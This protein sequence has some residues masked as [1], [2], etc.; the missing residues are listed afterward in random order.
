MNKLIPS[1]FGATRNS[2]LFVIGCMLL[3]ASVV[4]ANEDPFV[5][6]LE[7]EIKTIGDIKPSFIVYKDKPLPKV[8]INYILKRYIKLF[9]SANSPSVKI[10][11]LNRINNLRAKYQLDSKKLTIDK[12][13]QSKVVLDSY[14]KIVNSGVFYQ[15]MD[16]LL[17]QTAK[18]TKFTG[19]DKETIKRLKL[20]V[21]L[22]PKSDL[23]DESMF[24]I[25]ET[26]FDLGEF[27]KAEAH[28]K[29]V[30]AFSKESTFHHESNFKL[31]W[32]IFRQD[33]LEEAAVHA[34]K[35]LDKYPSLRNA[36]SYDSLGLKE[37][38]IV[39]DTFRLLSTMFSQKKGVEDI[40]LLQ[41]S[42]GHKDYAYLLYDSLFRFALG[43]ER[44]SD[45]G[46]VARGFADN[47]PTDFNA[48]RMAQN[49][50]KTYRRGNFDI[51]EW[52]AKEN[53][54][55]NFGINSAYWQSINDEQKSTVRPL[56]AEVLGELAHLY[57]VRMQTALAKVKVDTKSVE[58]ISS[59]SSSYY[60]Y[61]KQ[62]ADY[63]EEL[64]ATQNKDRHSGE[65][66]YLAAEAS[67][68]IG[69]YRRAISL[70]ER[71]AYE[72]ISHPKAVNAGYA[73]VLTYEDLKVANGTEGLELSSDDKNRRRIA[74]EKF[75]ANFPMAKETPSL[76]NDLANE[77]YSEND[78]VK[79]V[80]VSSRVASIR[81]APAAV[82][83]SSLLVNAHS[84]FELKQ[85]AQAQSA[86]Q[87]LLSYNKKADVEVLSERL[88]A[89]VYRQAENEADIA[90]SAELYL[91]VVDLVPDASFAPQ[92]LFDAST[93]LLK[94][95]RWSQAI[96]T[97]NV[98]QGRFPQHE[99]YAN[100]S[101]KLVFA[102]IENQ[103][104]V[105][106]AEK[107]VEISNSS[108][109]QT[110]ASNS[111]YRA[112]EIYLENDFAFEATNLFSAFIQKFPE[113]FELNLEAYFQNISYFDGRKQHSEANKWR[114]ELVDYEAANRNKRSD[115][116][117]YLAAN[118]ALSLID[119]DIDR[120]EEIQLTLPLKK[121]LDQKKRKLKLI[122]SSLEDLA[123]YEVSEVISAAT[124]KIATIYRIL[125]Q[126]IMSSER[127]DKL[128]ELQL[129][130][131][132]IL[133]EEQAYT[134]EEQ[135][136]EIYQI[137]LD[138]VPEG[139]YDEW[140]AASYEMLAEMNP[141]EFERKSKVILHADEYY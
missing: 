129:E 1:A 102:Y 135:A 11:A 107:L 105:P 85:F 45:A 39:D 24:R 130:Q 2:V 90:K 22:Y 141:T 14:D 134:F 137:N 109:D 124:Y 79:A 27:A 89:S 104:P 23:V 55:K 26:Y 42:V 15:R 32:S 38:D 116:S 91:R 123:D 100:A 19:N 92:A 122:V 62:A 138:K 33:R 21:G 93:Q 30:L 101:E 118:A 71:S 136:L 10:D 133:L 48:Y 53:F 31:G 20:L 18:A 8:S 117:A 7:N 140:I 44:F 36:I 63:Y 86:Y 51:Q 68:R 43:Q 120:F 108:N 6:E 25:A 121:S 73:S 84:H 97:L 61:G 41:T 127:P 5:F 46:L 13:T 78:Y 119:K 35:V 9:E 52:D 112:A 34:S 106:A 125:A 70:Y 40:E 128:T 132:D 82:L 94:L 96:A 103:E 57:Y 64:V 139:E 54:A 111:L 4:Q 77:F 75:A 114:H 98:F 110:I 28:Y 72:H 69:D 66:L 59:S 80:E 37:Q 81:T 29:K 3:S 115:R 99:L 87:K 131:Y 74:I 47:Y 56:V 113:Q 16:E 60:A 95:K 17:Y 50:I 67:Y 49:E 88:A 76:L 83:Y 58:S 126:D 65:H 12:V